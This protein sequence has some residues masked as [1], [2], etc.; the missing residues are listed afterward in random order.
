MRQ[1]LGRSV[2]I[3][4]EFFKDVIG[5]CLQYCRF[6]NDVTENEWY[7]IRRC[8]LMNTGSHNTGTFVHTSRFKKFT[9][10][11]LGSATYIGYWAL[12]KY[13]ALKLL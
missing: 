13:A 8:V 12:T 6:V 9:N 4:R 7:L 1:G 11:K 3:L 2:E 5:L 10:P